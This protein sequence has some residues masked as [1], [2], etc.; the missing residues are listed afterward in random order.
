M[1]LAYQVSTDEVY[2][3]P[4]V[5]SYQAEFETSLRALKASGYD[6]VELMVR[7]P[8]KLDFAK[9]EAAVK[10]FGFRC[11][12]VCTGEI[13]GQDKVCFADPKDEVRNEAVSRIKAAVDLASRFGKQINLGRARGGYL[14]GVVKEV[15]EKRIFDALREVCEYAERKK[16]VIALEPVN[17]LG[18]NYVNTTLEGLDL[19]VKVGSPSFRLMV[20]TAHIHIEDRDIEGALNAAKGF[21][22]F[23]HFADSNRKAPGMG[24]FDFPSFIRLLKDI[25]YDGYCSVEVFPVPDQDTALRESIAYLRPLLKGKEE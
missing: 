6:D 4:G 9:V 21:I 23:V 2:R 25:G 17:T 13:Y 1:K 15:T 3:Q 12:M 24:K 22:T 20:D 11:P 18:L 7:D 8:R 19:V 14:P 10:K 5:T 16:V